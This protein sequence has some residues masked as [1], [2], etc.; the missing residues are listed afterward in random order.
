[1]N[2]AD[3]AYKFLRRAEDGKRP[4]I[5]VEKHFLEDFLGVLA[6]EGVLFAR[7]CVDQIRDPEVRSII[8]TVFFATA[9]GAVLGAT[10]GLMVAGPVG[11]QVG[12]AVGTVVG[13]VSAV[14]ALV[15]TAE[16]RGNRVRIA[17]A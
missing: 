16:S 10:V 5:D 14:A 3:F 1:M 2:V 17:L 7:H 8:E 15:I 6:R 12:A 4:S 11:A 9:G 13:V